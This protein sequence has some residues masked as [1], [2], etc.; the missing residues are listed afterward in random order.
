MKNKKP[1][2]LK[3]DK[4]KT[5]KS[6]ISII[7]FIIFIICISYLI[8]NY[9]TKA[10]DKKALNE[11]QEAEQN[12]IE[13]NVEPTKTDKMIEVEELKASNSE[14]I[15]WIKIDN[16]IID[17]PIVQGEDNDYYLTHNYK[18]EDSKHGSIFL[19]NQCD[20]NDVNSNLIIYGHNMKDELMFN[21]LLKYEDENF[22]N[23]HKTVNITTENE[24]RQYEI[25]AVFK[26]RVFYK[27]EKNVFRYYDYL[28]FEDENQYNE[29]INNVKTEQLY[30][31]G[32]T[33]N[34]GEQL[35]TLITCEYSQENGRMVVVAKR[36]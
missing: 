9:Y 29:Y 10:K 7:F 20:F 14:I 11:I 5:I 1:K 33:A 21:S 35:L 34:Y 25:V 13:E 2:R 27:K 16:T 12:I 28:K 6:V 22:Y 30:D 24:E 18:K 32:V 36:K 17:Y 23:E 4:H 26:S 31:T 19:K 3:E 8:Y 15:G